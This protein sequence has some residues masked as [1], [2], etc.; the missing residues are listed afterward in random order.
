MTTGNFYLENTANLPPHPQ[1][2]QNA[3][4]NMLDGLSPFQLARVSRSYN[5]P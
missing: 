3:E 1:P 4:K 2:P 5:H